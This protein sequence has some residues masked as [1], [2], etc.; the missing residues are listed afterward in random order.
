MPSISLENCGTRRPS[1]FGAGQGKAP[2]VLAIR[3]A[4]LIGIDNS[5]QLLR[6]AAE[7]LNLTGTEADLRLASAYKTGLPDN[8]VDVG[9][10]I[11]ILHH[12][13]LP[14]ARQEVFH[15]LRPGGELIGMEDRP[16]F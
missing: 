10:C 14:R 12:L 9:F 2:V 4:R 7:R 3:G 16:R 6:L 1:I 11:A 8:F 13:D 5:P 15:I